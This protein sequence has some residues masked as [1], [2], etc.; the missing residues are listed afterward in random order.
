MFFLLSFCSSSTS[1]KRHI[2]CIFIHT[3]YLPLSASHPHPQYCKPPPA[4]K[5]VPIG[6]KRKRGRPAKA[7]PALLLQWLDL[8]S[9]HFSYMFFWTPNSSCV[10][11]LEFISCFIFTRIKSFSHWQKL[12]FTDQTWIIYWSNSN[13]LLTKF[14]LFTDQTSIFYRQFSIKKLTIF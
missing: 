6:E 12:N 3:Y 4:A 10:H 8:H 13:Y 7:K 5:T 9:L 11:L 2:R 1:S 14:K